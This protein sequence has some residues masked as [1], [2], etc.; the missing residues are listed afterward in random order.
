MVVGRAAMIPLFGNAFNYDFMLEQRTLKGRP[1]GEYEYRVRRPGDNFALP[2]VQDRLVRNGDIIEIS[3]ASTPY[4]DKLVA[5]VREKAIGNN[6]EIYD[7][8][9]RWV[10]SIADIIN[11]P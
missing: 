8:Q 10:P 9:G 2:I 6:G 3:R 4:A 7:S 11:I 1:V 5:L